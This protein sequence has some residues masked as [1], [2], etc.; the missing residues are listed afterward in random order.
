MAASTIYLCFHDS[1]LYQS[2]LVTFAEGNW[3]NDHS[4]LFAYEYFHRIEFKDCGDD[5]LFMHPANTLILQYGDDED[6][7]NLSEGLCFESRKVVFIPVNNSLNDQL[8]KGTHWSLLVYVKS[9]NKFL[10]FDSM[11][12]ASMNQQAAA[13]IVQ[14]LRTH[15]Y[16]GATYANGNAPKQQN[17]SDCGMYLLCT[18]QLLGQY[19]VEGVDLQNSRL[20]R[21]CTQEHVQKMRQHWPKVIESIRDSL[22]S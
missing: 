20:L 8:N 10:H 16:P 21:E 19:F 1:T 3:L 7:T 2:D 13:S 11:G 5:V 14:N 17:G 18:S 12:A 22:K 15:V 6:F 4:I 9:A